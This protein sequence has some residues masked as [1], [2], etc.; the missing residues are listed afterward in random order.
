MANQRNDIHITAE[1]VERFKAGLISVYRLSQIKN[2]DKN[3]IKG[4][5]KKLG[6]PVVDKLLA[7]SVAE[8]KEYV[9]NRPSNLSKKIINRLTD[10]DVKTYMARGLTMEDLAS[11]YGVST[12]VIKRWLKELGVTDEMRQA[13]RDKP[14][15]H[16]HVFVKHKAFQLM[17]EALSVHRP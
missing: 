13:R 15:Q 6:D 1:E 17:D 2:C 8:I 3:S 5:L 11:H 4:R 12:V 7:M 14:I 9:L 10:D 16:K